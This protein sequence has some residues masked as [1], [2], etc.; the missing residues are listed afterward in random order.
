[1]SGWLWSHQRCRERATWLSLYPAGNTQSDMATKQWSCTDYV[2]MRECDRWMCSDV[3]VKR[4]AE[5]N[6]DHHFYKLV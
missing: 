2:I 6:T 3:T 4:G 1:M 5:C